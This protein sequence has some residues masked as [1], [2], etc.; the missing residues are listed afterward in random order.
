MAGGV[1]CGPERRSRQ[2]HAVADEGENESALGS[3]PGSTSIMSTTTHPS[4]QQASPG[5]RRPTIPLIDTQRERYDM[6][7]LKRYGL[8]FFY[9]HLMLRGRG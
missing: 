3:S 4:W 9:W 5:R 1:G 6:W 7:L 8:P 2:H